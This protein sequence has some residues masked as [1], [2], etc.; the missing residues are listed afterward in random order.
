MWTLQP[1]GCCAPPSPSSWRVFSGVAAH[2]ALP[3]CGSAAGRVS[4]G[5]SASGEAGVTA[6]RSS[7]SRVG[8]ELP[9]GEAGSPGGGEE[10][11]K[12]QAPGRGGHGG[13]GPPW[14]WLAQGGRGGGGKA[15]SGGVGN[16]S[17]PN[18]WKIPWTLEGMWT[19]GWEGLGSPETRRGPKQPPLRPTGQ[20]A[21][22]C[23]SGTQAPLW[24]APG[25]VPREPQ[26]LLSP[27]PSR[28]ADSEEPS[29]LS[30]RV[31]GQTPEGS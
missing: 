2:L 1:R 24:L 31:W 15:G 4:K 3:G 14:R 20:P 12:G 6:A 25:S 19:G 5:R 11:V 28:S 30:K 26:G 23:Q 21:G 18:G 8:E 22:S 27:E 29:S 9:V 16:S 13:L 10:E 7:P 17:G